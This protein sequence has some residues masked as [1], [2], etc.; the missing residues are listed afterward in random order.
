M[1]KTL[2]NLKQYVE[3]LLEH[4]P[5]EQNAEKRA[6]LAVSFLAECRKLKSVLSQAYLDQDNATVSSQIRSVQIELTQL[7]DHLYTLHDS[8][9]FNEHDLS[10]T[11]NVYAELMEEVISSLCY[12]K[13][14]FPEIFNTQ[15]KAPAGLK[16]MLRQAV[17]EKRE[18]I[19]RNILSRQIDD[20]LTLIISR[21][22]SSLDGED[23]HLLKS[24]C[25][26]DYMERFI[27]TLS[28]ID[29]P[30]NPDTIFQSLVQ[31]LYF[32][33]FNTTQF[34]DYSRG[35]LEKLI[36]G[37][38]TFVEQRRELL[39]VLRHITHFLELPDLACNPKLPS[40]K[41]MV[42][43]YIN[44]EIDYLAKTEHL[45]TGTFHNK[46]RHAF[47][48]YFHVN[49]TTEQLMFFVRLLMETGIIITKRK[50]DLYEF[51]SNHVGTL[52]KD[53]L[54]VSSIKNKQYSVS[55]DVIQKVKTILLKCINLANQKYNCTE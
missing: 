31:Q 16:N 38:S 42:V 9:I 51:I 39:L 50:A 49:L 37:Y 34:Y 12:L 32:I 44:E 15:L 10:D 13:D 17:V 43:S 29:T 46:S 28:S 47:P 26:F 1:K 18:S 55:K 27:D 23:E 5:L 45:H 33:N 24:W 19:T 40:V 6:A 3:S 14:G 8:E 35:W 54:S 4:A 53:N 7:A 36:D 41:H 48:F 22:L 11:Y 30:G 21:Y 20:D 52:R 2:T 25:D